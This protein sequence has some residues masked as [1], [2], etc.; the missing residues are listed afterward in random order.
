MKKGLMILGNVI[1]IMALLAFI[2]LNVGSESQ[3]VS[4]GGTEAHG[5]RHEPVVGVEVAHTARC[6]H[7]V[8]VLPR[9]A[10]LVLVDDGVALKLRHGAEV[11]RQ[12]ALSHALQAV[13]CK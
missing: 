5:G 9:L 10:V 6:Q 11:V 8:V 4:L 2:L 1:I 13:A 12:D 7:Q 3:L